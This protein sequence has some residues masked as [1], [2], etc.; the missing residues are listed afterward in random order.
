MNAMGR[1]F[2]A[3]NILI[4]T[5]YLLTEVRKFVYI[6]VNVLQMSLL[7][8]VNLGWESGV[9][10]QTC[11]H[12]LHLDC[13]LPYVKSLDHQEIRLSLAVDINEY[14][15][16]LCRQLANCFLPLSPR[17]GNRGQIV[18]SPSVPFST[19]LP[20]INNL[21]AEI[22]SHALTVSHLLNFIYL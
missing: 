3:V 19:I 6:F 13:L 8:S 18:R 15:C 16:P 5:C 14:L 7:L 12:H 1:H 20:E 10:V 11:G 21:L 2:N 4:L 22:K 9:Y 17:L